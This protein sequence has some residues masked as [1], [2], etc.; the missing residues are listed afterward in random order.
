MQKQKKQFL[1]VFVILLFCVVGYV[2]LTQYNKAQEKKEKEKEKAETITLTDWKTKD[3]EA[4]SYPLDGK[5]LSFTKDADGNW[6]CE[7]DP[8]VSLDEE[9]INTM[10][11]N[12]AGLTAAE[13][14]DDPEDLSEY[15][16]TDDS[17]KLT[18]TTA[19]GTTTFTLGAE[20]EINNQYYLQM[21]GDD[22]V[23]LIEKSLETSFSQSMDDLKKEDKKTEDSSDATSE[24]TE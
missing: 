3:I 2:A 6:T 17:S 13:E 21:S 11:E 7:D 14:I 23:Y 19:D 8:S 20:N 1:V 4:F 15:G 24:A 18:F 9:K 10:L 12:V 22:H 5:T 16:I